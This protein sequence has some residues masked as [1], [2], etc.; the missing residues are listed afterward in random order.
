MPY[1]YERRRHIW[2]NAFQQ[3]NVLART[4]EKGALPVGFKRELARLNSAQIDWRTHLWRYLVQ[5][6][7]DFQN[8]DRRFIGRGLYLEALEG[9]SV[10]IFVCLDTSGSVNDAQVRALVSEVQAILRS[11]PHLKCDLY[12]ADDKLYGPY[13]LHAD[14]EIPPPLGGGGTD[15]QPFLPM[16]NSA[17]ACTRAVSPST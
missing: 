10:R 11:Y 17:A 15:F 13:L 8:F 3:V 5:T 6:P 12:Y 2:R 14:S 9:E 4:L 7:T 16:L 1:A